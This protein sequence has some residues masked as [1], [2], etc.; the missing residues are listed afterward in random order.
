M[1][2]EQLTASFGW[3][4]S[5][6]VIQHDAQELNRVLFNAIE[7]S[8]VGTPGSDL[9]NRL[10]GGSLVNLTQ[11]L[12]CGYVSEREEQFLDLTIPVVGSANVQ[13]SLAAYTAMEELRGNNQYHC[14]G[15]DTLVDAQ[16]GVRLRR[17]PPILTL[18]L[19][20]FR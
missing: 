7:K 5:D 4:R 1:R 17:L 19:N 13:A 16:R 8:L 10:Y 15:C 14:G 9:I 20:R 3:T 18:G 6:E 2:T 11:C 12:M